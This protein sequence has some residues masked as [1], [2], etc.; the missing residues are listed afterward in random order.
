MPYAADHNILTAEEIADETATLRQL[1]ARNRFSPSRIQRGLCDLATVAATAEATARRAA[2]TIEQSPHDLSSIELLVTAARGRR[3]AA[4]ARARADVL[5]ELIGGRRERNHTHT[6]TTHPVTDMQ[7][8]ACGLTP[9]SAVRID[10]DYITAC[11]GALINTARD[12]YALVYCSACDKPDRPLI[13]RDQYQAETCAACGRTNTEAG[14]PEKWTFHWH[15]PRGVSV[16][17]Q[18]CGGLCADKVEAM[19][20]HTGTLPRIPHSAEGRVKYAP[21]TT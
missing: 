19:R 3:T 5:H 12:A 13:H 9:T 4:I 18:S 8:C 21:T 2:A 20:D 7:L 11:C 6:F 15:I 14:S 10:P 16:S 17:A 1:V